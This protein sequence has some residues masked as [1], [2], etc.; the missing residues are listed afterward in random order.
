MKLSC[1][2]GAVT[3]DIQVIPDSLTSCNCSTCHRYGAL[4]GYFK[5][6]EVKI[7][8]NSIVLQRYAWA[9]EN[10]YF[11]HCSKCGCVTH[12]ETTE[13]TESPPLVA[14]NF[15][16]ANPVDIKSVK[17]RKFDGAETWKYLD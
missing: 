17:V 8:D 13:K 6:D 7:E 9:D 4:W 16:M 2:C 5:P 10:I 12:Y 3:I 11:C 1:H 15:R 14:L